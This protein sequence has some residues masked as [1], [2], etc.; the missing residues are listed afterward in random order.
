VAYRV[1]D[2]FDAIRKSME[3]IRLLRSSTMGLYHLDGT[4]LAYTLN[5][6]DFAELAAKGQPSVIR[7]DVIV[8]T[9]QTPHNH[10]ALLS[11]PS[12]RLAFTVP[13]WITPGGPINIYVYLK[14]A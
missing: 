8:C 1:I 3:Q 4:L 2:D 11:N 14:A 12:E 9:H 5:P 10:I 7:F 13:G 6:P